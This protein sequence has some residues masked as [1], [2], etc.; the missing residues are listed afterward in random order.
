[1]K[2]ET[3]ILLKILNPAAF[4]IALIVLYYMYPLMASI[5]TDI[6]YGLA[7]IFVFG[8]GNV[9]LNHRFISILEKVKPSAPKRFLFTTWGR[10]KINQRPDDFFSPED[11]QQ[12]RAVF[13]FMYLYLGLAM[14][15]LF[16]LVFAFAWE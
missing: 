13:R 7:W 9:L 2:K 3:I 12:Y 14:I 16:F 6:V 1:M 10:S 4:L 11:Y 8:L 15:V 5:H